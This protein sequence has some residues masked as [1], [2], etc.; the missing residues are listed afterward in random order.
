[1]RLF[2]GSFVAFLL[3]AIPSQ[4][5]AQEMTK[6]QVSKIEAEVLALAE[7]WIEGWEE[8]D[9]EKSVS[10]MHPERLAFLYGGKPLNRSGEVLGGKAIVLTPKAAVVVFTA[11]Q[12][13]T[14]T[15]G[16]TRHY[17][18]SAYTGLVELTET[19]WLFTTFSFSNG[20]Y[21]SG[22]GG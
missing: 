4:S 14:Y 6:E 9:C 8:L 15:D 11:E 2:L 20:S 5:S 18:S 12:F 3:L 7:S 17:P 1:M 10:F 19:G 13:Y 16:S 21:V 22:E